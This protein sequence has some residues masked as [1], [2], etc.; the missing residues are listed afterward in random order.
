MDSEA[1]VAAR[2]SE[3]VPKEPAPAVA[4]VQPAQ[5]ETGDSGYASEMPF[6]EITRYRLL[7]R[8]KVPQNYWSDPQ[9]NS[10]IVFIYQ[11][12]SDISQSTDYMDVMA[13]LRR[14]EGM[15]GGANNGIEGLYRYAK[16]DTQ[17]RKIE[18]EMLNG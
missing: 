9:I 4:T 15:L 2:L 18:R 12:A 7:E 5:S 3:N 16:L 1:V 17:R 6:D 10:K 13:Y 14:A 8:F 11:W